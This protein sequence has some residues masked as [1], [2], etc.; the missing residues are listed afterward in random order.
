MQIV[1]KIVLG[2]V[3]LIALL[4]IIALF[5]PRSYTVSVTDT[6]NKPKSEVFEYAKILKNQQYY[7]V[8]VMADPN[9]KITYTGVDGTVGATQSW[10]SKDDNVGAG[11]QTITAISDD[12]IDVDLSFIRPF[13]GK[14]KA[15]NIIKAVNDNQTTVT[16]EFYGQDAYPMNLMGYWFGRGMI[17]DAETK[18]LKNLKAILE[19]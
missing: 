9:A 15:A 12:R 13:E 7:S 16:S 14:A 11:T 18:N 19:K 17:K 6:V 8:W 2:L 1:K 10:D 5:T 4:L 3:A